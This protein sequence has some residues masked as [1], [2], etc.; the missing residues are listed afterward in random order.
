M[1]NLEKD[2]SSVVNSPLECSEEHPITLKRIC[3][4]CNGRTFGW[5]DMGTSMLCETCN[6]TGNEYLGIINSQKQDYL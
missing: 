3:V 4:V 5:D 6:G 2:K 1:T